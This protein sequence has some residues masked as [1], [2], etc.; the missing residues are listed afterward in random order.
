MS[1]K[2][3]F[4]HVTYPFF[5][6]QNMNIEPHLK[7]NG[8]EF[9]SQIGNGQ[10]SNVWEATYIKTKS[11]V[12]IKCLNS[13]DE[14]LKEKAINEIL[15]N[16]KI[17]HPFISQYI[18][19][20]EMN[21]TF[22][23]VF[24]NVYE[25]LAS[26][27]NKTGFLNENAAHK[28]FF[29][30]VN[31]IEFLHKT[32]KIIHRDIKVENILLDTSRNIR[33]IDFGLACV[34]AS[35]T[36]K[37][38]QQVGSIYYMPPE[39]IKNEDYDFSVD[40]WSMGVVLYAITHGHLPFDTYNMI[41]SL[42]TNILNNEPKINPAIN[43][44]LKDLLF[45]M[46]DKN[47][48]TRITLDQIKQHQWYNKIKYPDFK[49]KIELI[50]RNILRSLKID[51]SIISD[52]LQKSQEESIAERPNAFIEY[53]LSYRKKLELE[54]K[55]Q[56]IFKKVEQP[57]SKPS[58]FTKPLSN[59]TKPSTKK[60]I[61]SGTRKKSKSPTCVSSLNKMKPGRRLTSP[62]K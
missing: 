3:N 41:D 19:Y 53:L 30:L 8:Y 58:A 40:I 11:N 54:I 12:A 20:F 17:F 56:F 22:F 52:N 18:N 35:N 55:N 23:L 28:I 57:A 43:E 50:D 34:K 26:F 10:F 21:N 5:Q 36:M 49:D 2:D 1:E 4:F 51:Q 9:I 42:K 33:L 44:H 15:I 47:P 7:V 16:Q 31:A 27:S 25:D 24:E 48:K 46:L 39:M 61:V 59:S 60:P 32:Y 6:K 29:Q 62:K 45:K 13:N 14:K 38:N 37:I